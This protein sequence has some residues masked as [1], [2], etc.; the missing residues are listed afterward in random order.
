M[1]TAGREVKGE[2]W[3]KDGYGRGRQRERQ[4]ERVNKVVRKDRSPERNDSTITQITGRK[5]TRK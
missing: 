5:I 3:G 2:N 4:R 1:A